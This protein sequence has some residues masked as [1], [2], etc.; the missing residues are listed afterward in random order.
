MRNPGRAKIRQLERTLTKA[1]KVSIMVEITILAEKKRYTLLHIRNSNEFVV[2]LDFDN[3]K[4][5]GQMWAHGHYF[6][7]DVI[8]A[9]DFFRGKTTGIYRHSVESICANALHYLHE[10][11][12]LFDFA[13]NYDIEFSQNELD[14]FGF[15][16]IDEEEFW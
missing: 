8:S 7:D 9:T 4:P 13:E 3:S 10:N 2:A 6:N 14:Y 1:R 11:D 12:M 5:F 15:A 16:D